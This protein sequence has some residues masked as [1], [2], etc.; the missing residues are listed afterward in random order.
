MTTARSRSVALVLAVLTAVA[1]VLVGATPASAAD[2]CSVSWGSLPKAHSTYDAEV[3]T[4]SP[5]GPR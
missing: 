2:R 3:A 5:S 1:A 4:P